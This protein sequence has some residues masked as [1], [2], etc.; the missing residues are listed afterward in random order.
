MLLVAYLCGLGH[1][2]LELLNF[3]LQIRHG[4]FVLRN[5][6]SQLLNRSL[7]LLR[8]GGEVIPVGLVVVKLLV[9]PRVVLGLLSCLSLQSIDQITD[10]GLY[11][12]HGIAMLSGRELRSQQRKC[13]RLQ[14]A[15]SLLDEFQQLRPLAGGRAAKRHQ[16]HTLHQRWQMLRRRPSHRIRAQNLSGLLERLDL[17]RPGF[18][19]VVVVVS[20][21]CALGIEL[22]QSLLVIVA[23]GSCCFQISCGVGRSFVGVA[24]GNSLVATL[25]LVV[26]N[27]VGEVHHIQ[28]VGM[29]PVSFAVNECLPLC[30]GLLQ[31]VLNQVKDSRGVSLVCSSFRSAQLFAAGKKSLQLSAVLMG[32]PDLQQCSLLFLIEHP[33]LDQS[34]SRGCGIDALSHVFVCGRIIFVFHLPDL[35]G[36]VEVALVNAD[37]LIQLGNLL[38]QLADVCLALSDHG[39]Q[40]LDLF[41][42]F[43]D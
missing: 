5:G 27:L 16:R 30:F 6:R 24:A 37:I 36:S 32:H 4:L 19:P 18:S 43:L 17:L 14:R 20:L 38:G 11:L 3:A 9:A 33:L 39:L 42:G 41:V 29:G 25:G 28:L 23:A 31:H 34:H 26:L 22:R 2:S 1:G 12:G 21:L 8:L 15:G 40:R 7:Q 13:L 35:S 10:H